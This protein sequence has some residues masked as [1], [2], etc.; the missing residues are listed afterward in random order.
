MLF[1]EL[2]EQDE[3]EAL[4]WETEYLMYLLTKIKDGG[5]TSE[6]RVT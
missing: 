6:V 5:I 1:S 4:L 3:C 2:V